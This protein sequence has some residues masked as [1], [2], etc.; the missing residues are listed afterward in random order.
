MVNQ[1]YN[2]VVFAGLAGAG[3]TGTSCSNDHSSRIPIRSKGNKAASPSKFAALA[4]M[5]AM[6]SAKKE[7]ADQQPNALARSRLENM[8]KRREQKEKQAAKTDEDEETPKRRDIIRPDSTFRMAWD[9]CMLV[10]IVYNVFSVP[11][12]ICF[13]VRDTL[14]SVELISM[15]ASLPPSSV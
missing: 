1:T 13:A 4:S 5:A 14:S 15:S 7:N 2:N 3:A 10:L 6:A 8:Q 9:M 11:V 12:S